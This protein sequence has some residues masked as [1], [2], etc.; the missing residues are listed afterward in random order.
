MEETTEKEIKSPTNQV[1]IS[2]VIFTTLRRW[3]WLILSIA[4]FVG[5]AVFYILRTPPVYTRSASIV[6][7][8]SSTG[9]SISDIS[10]FSEMGLVQTSS[11][12]NDE[13]NKLQ[14]PDVMDEVV[15]RLGLDKSYSTE[16]RF[17]REI[18]YGSSLPVTIDFPTLTESESGSATIDIDG[19]GS[20]TLSDVTLSG[21]RVTLPNSGRVIPGDTIRTAQGNIVVN[22]TGRGSAKNATIYVNK[23]PLSS[24][25]AQFIGEFGVALKS[26]SGNTINLTATDY[27]PERAVDLL[28]G[29]IAVYNEKWLQD[30]NQVSVST[31]NFINERLA[32]IESELG[33]ID[34]DIASYQSEHLIPNIQQ[35]ASMYMSENQEAS[36]QMLNLNNQLQMTRYLRNY[37]GSA[38]GKNEILPANTGI[39]NTAI[40]GQI[41][42]YNSMMLD[43]NQKIA[44]SSETHPIVA[45]LDNRLSA[46]RASIVSSLDNQLKALET[47][48]RNLQSSKSTTTSQ[49]A[50]APTQ[51]NYLLT[52][53]RQQK[54]KES[55]YLF[56]LQKREENELSQ[57]FTAYNTEVIKRPS[58]SS[59]P[60]APVRDKIILIAFVIGLALPFGVTYLIESTNTRIRG[61]K[62]IDGLSIPFLGEIPDDKPK[63]GERQESRVVVKQ[64]KRNVVNE[65]FRVLRTNLGFLTGSTKGNVV[66]ITSFNPGSGKTFIAMNTAVSL[67]I[68]G[69]RVVVIDGD[70]RRCSTS[71]YIDTPET[72][73]SN[74]LVGETD[75]LSD[76]IYSDSLIPGLS[77]IPV[78][79]IP[80]NPTELLESPRFAEL[81]KTLKAD[82]DYILIDCPPVEMMAD[83]QIIETLVDRTIFVI[84]AGLFERAMLPEL[85]RLYDQKKY[86]NMTLVLNATAA[87]GSRHGYKYGYGYGYGYG[88]YS[89]YTKKD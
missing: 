39:G 76:I 73:L 13:I 52:V 9:N 69:K 29:V 37:L 82:Y 81:I 12:I 11:N 38:S 46:M 34:K 77:V 57:A 51:A 50:A 7:K 18:L 25:T 41:G 35:A 84:R 10:A 87:E 89:H 86:R 40:E 5:A 74:Y 36:S 68:K 66:M 31:A 43:R 56:L 3:P 30:R 4:L 14:S 16:G 64:G 88:N 71:V 54:V 24:A 61:R 6:I 70:M 47:Q 15:R 48:M 79:T 20:I 27:S 83:A 59:A 26:N 2:D 19:K 1:K 63:K 32:V 22:L 58:G 8:S 17:H 23:Q 65:A 45:D 80:P 33:G 53:E 78:G 44:N 42:Q 75:R 62:D 21:E 72:G 49:L 28:N 60:T 85:Q 67:A 55:L